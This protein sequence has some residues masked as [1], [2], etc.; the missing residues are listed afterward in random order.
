MAGWC[1]AAGLHLRPWDRL[2]EAQ[3]GHFPNLFSVSNTKLEACFILPPPKFVNAFI[4]H[5]FYFGRSKNGRVWPVVCFP[6]L[7]SWKAFPQYCLHYNSSTLFSLVLT[8]GLAR[9]FCWK[10]CKSISI[11]P[12]WCCWSMHACGLKTAKKPPGWDLTYDCTKVQWFLKVQMHLCALVTH[13][14]QWTGEN[15]YGIRREKNVY[16]QLPKHQFQ[17]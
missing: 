7:P 11:F 2:I 13:H 17:N 16:G 9:R 1:Q 8:L 6:V 5:F 15:S 4:L 12:F 10:C 14:W 3:S